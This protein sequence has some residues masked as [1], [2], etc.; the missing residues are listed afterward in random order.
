MTLFALYQSPAEAGLPMAVGER[1]SWFA[2]LLPPVHALL[3]RH[4]GQLGLFV[5]ALAVL[6][7]GA[8]FLG[9]EAACWLYLPVAL[10][11][12][13]AAPGAGRR[14]LRRRGY[15]PAGHVFAADADLARLAFLENTP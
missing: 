4:W 7:L 6:V 11:F 13:F 10:A 1:F 2:F 15:A 3:H 14:A 5:L 8:R 9:A 12:G